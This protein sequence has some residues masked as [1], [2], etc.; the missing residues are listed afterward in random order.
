MDA[1]AGAGLGLRSQLRPAWQANGLA[2]LRTDKYVDVR[3][4]GNGHSFAAVGAGKGL[5]GIGFLVFAFRVYGWHGAIVARHAVN[6]SCTSS[7]A[8]SLPRAIREPLQYVF[9]GY[10]PALLR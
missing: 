5:N 4:L 2:A 7:Y 1:A 8:A 6:N 10:P 3:Q 9:G